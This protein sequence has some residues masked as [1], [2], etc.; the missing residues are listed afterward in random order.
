MINFPTK[1][2]LQ[3]KKEEK[4]QYI[5]ELLE[6]ID[7]DAIKREHERSFLGET[8]NDNKLLQYADKEHSKRLLEAMKLLVDISENP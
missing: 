7:E 8:D 6:S 2:E 5:D 4:H 1:E 3:R